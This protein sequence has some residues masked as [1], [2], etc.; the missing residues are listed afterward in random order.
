MNHYLLMYRP[1]RETFITDATAE[2]SAA[3][4]RHFDYL[5]NLL[6]DGK[7]LMAGRVED[8]RLGIAI[9]EAADD[10]AAAS[11]MAHD[12]AVQA[13]VFS[14]ELLPFRLALMRE[15]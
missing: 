5:S 12:P 7:L 3:V 4:S 15:N 1:Q 11:I 9:L 8:A 10:D 2:E 6:A 13:G 14:G